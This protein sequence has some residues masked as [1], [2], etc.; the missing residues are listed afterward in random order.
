MASNEIRTVPFRAEVSSK[1]S[2]QA[3]AQQFESILNKGLDDGWEYVSVNDVNVEIAS[4]CFGALMG[5][6][7]SYTTYDVIT[8]EKPYQPKPKPNYILSSKESTI[9]TTIES[10]DTLPKSHIQAR[11]KK[12]IIDSSALIT[13]GKDLLKKNKSITKKIIYG[14]VILSLIGFVS[15]LLPSTKDEVNQTTIKEIPIETLI[16]DFKE[17][18]KNK[19]YQKANEVLLTIEDKSPDSNFATSARAALDKKLSAIDKSYNKE[20][21]TT[22]SG[23][24]QD[25]SAIRFGLTESQRKQ[26]FM[27]ITASEDKAHKYRRLKEDKVLELNYDKT[28]L[29]EEFAQIDKEANEL[30]RKYRNQVL[31]KYNI[32]SEQEKILS[33]EGFNKNWPLD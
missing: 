7:K 5:S 9:I 30:K 27:D 15:R 2:P 14:V 17:L 28:R 23:A 25:Y 8:F 22:E 11:P 24:Q 4:G 12:S 13:K 31:K 10:S 1:I 19:E 6:G 20:I 21:T 33:E 16:K 3:I 32:S 26:L 18:Y 29:K